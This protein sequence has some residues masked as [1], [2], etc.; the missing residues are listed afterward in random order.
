MSEQS[1]SSLV[2]DLRARTAKLEKDLDS[3]NA[4]IRRKMQ[5]QGKTLNRELSTMFSKLGKVAAFA[6][7]TVGLNQIRGAVLDVIDTSSALQTTADKLGLTTTALQELRYAGEQFNVDQRTTDMAL[8]RFGRR[9]AEV[10]QGSGQLKATL[11]QY[12]ISVRNADGSTRGTLEVLRDFADALHDA[13]NANE[14][15]RMSMNA[16][17]SEGVAFGQVLRDGARGL[18]ELTVQSHAFGAIIESDQVRRLAALDKRLNDV[19]QGW[20]S[21]KAELLTGAL[22]LTDALGLTGSMAELDRLAGL[23]EQAQ[24]TAAVDPSMLVFNSTAMTAPI[25][26]DLEKTKVEYRAALM[27]MVEDT[28]VGIQALS[29]ELQNAEA[30]LSTFDPNSDD[31]KLW[32]GEI[33]NLRGQL[34]RLTTQEQLLIDKHPKAIALRQMLIDLDQG[35]ANSIALTAQE[36]AQLN[37]ILAST[38]NPAERLQEQFDLL[39]RAIEAMPARTEEF[40][41]AMRR[42]QVA[43][44]E[45]LKPDKMDRLL[46]AWEDMADGMSTSISEALVEGGDAVDRFLVRT[47]QK[48]QAAA[49]ESAIINPLLG[50]LGIKS[51][52][53]SGGGGFDWGSIIKSYGTGGRPIPGDPAIIGERGPEL[54]MPD[55]PGTILPNSVLN[56]ISGTAST[57]GGG[58]ITVNQTIRFDVGLESVDHRIRN[59]APII[60]LATEAKIHDTMRRRGRSL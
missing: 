33:E 1:L 50:A 7:V 27:G 40:E 58:N 24:K 43:Y 48:L 55:R 19:T 12:G 41:E 28:R 38:V 4:K 15:M 39:N 25:G 17:D 23:I 37:S 47:L 16:F 52:G 60:A 53:E 59:A 22:D 56:R 34:E 10:A 51:G 2:I 35:R 31:F 30:T 57:S 29:Q 20:K 14:Q 13:E 46:D 45:S 5:A 42:L 18:A 54:W 11:D 32:S 36:M 3:A 44:D 49:L 21:M 9:L 8:Q 6:G 26:I